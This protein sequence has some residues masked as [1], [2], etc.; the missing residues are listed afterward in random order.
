MTVTALISGGK[1]SVYAAYLAEMQGWRIDELLT[2]YPKDLESKMFHTPN[3]ELVPLLARAWG[4]PHRAVRAE[5]EGEEAEEQALRGALE[6]RPGVV[7]TGAIASSYQYDRLDR[8]CYR[9]GHRLYAPLWQKEAGRV[10][11]A[12]IE[13]GLDIRLT[14]LAAEPLTRELA[15]RRLDTGMLEE[16]ARRSERIRAVHLAG[17]GGE[18]ET[19]VVDAP[20]FGSRL[21]WDREEVI[22]EQH[23]TRWRPVGVRLEE[24]GARG[25]QRV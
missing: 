25:P 4:R 9:L 22:S 1:D 6:G 12:E 11:R 15:G 19:L 14:H 16:I 21:L 24:K 17:E 23:T 10:V 7:V 3:L 2:L 13:A 20:F 5:A 8:L 18:Y